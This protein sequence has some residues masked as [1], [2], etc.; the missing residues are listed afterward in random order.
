MQSLKFKSVG[1]D[2]LY[3]GIMPVLSEAIGMAVAMSDTDIPY[4]ISFTIQ[5]N[6]KL[7]DGHTI[8][9]AIYY[10]NNHVSNKPVC[11]MTNCVHPDIVYEA[12]SHKFNQTQMVKNRFWGIQALYPHK[13]INSNGFEQTGLPTVKGY[14][15]FLV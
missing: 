11:Y 15:L 8:N 10:I 2:F 1:V 13:K 14:C 6:G 5:R 4:I 3:A 7:I 12:L 9:D